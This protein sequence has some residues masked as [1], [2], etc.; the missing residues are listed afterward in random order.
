[1]VVLV[2]TEETHHLSFSLLLQ[3]LPILKNQFAHLVSSY[4][5]C[6]YTL[7][8]SLIQQYAHRG[9]DPV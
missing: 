6:S 3:L 1:M 2:P 8:I 5:S 9:T 4:F 7:F